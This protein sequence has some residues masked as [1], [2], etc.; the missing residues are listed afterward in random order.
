MASG[1]L[2]PKLTLSTYAVTAALIN[3]NFGAPATGAGSHPDSARAFNTQ[4]ILT[5]RHFQDYTTRTI[6]SVAIQEVY[7]TEVIQLALHH[8]CLM[9]AI[10]S[11]GAIHVRALTW[12]TSPS[13][14]SEVFHWNQTLGLFSKKLAQPARPDDA[15]ALLATATLINGIA[16]AMTDERDARTSW[17]WTTDAQDDELRWLRLQRGIQL[18]FLETK[19]LGEKGAFRSLFGG[20]EYLED[21]YRANGTVPDFSSTSAP[22][23]LRNFAA[24]CQVKTDSDPSTNA[25]FTPLSLLASDVQRQSPE[26]GGNANEIFSYLGFIGFASNAYIALLKAKDHR[27]MLLLCCWYRVVGK[28][29]CWWVARRARLEWRIIAEY[30]DKFGGDQVRRCLALIKNI[31]NEA[32]ESCRE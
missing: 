8:P 27:A 5:L 7:R 28:L 23:I 30:L 12:S 19:D 10:L 21:Q 32:R 22:A 15:N 29:D 3:Q 16:F 26:N 20:E 31:E 6:G 13:S 14:K 18:V 17:P 9:H 24:L 4:D 2:L 1:H 25:Y 11:F